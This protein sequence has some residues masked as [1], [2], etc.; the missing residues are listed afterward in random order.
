MG[1]RLELFDARRSHIEAFAKIFALLERTSFQSPLLRE[2]RARL[3]VQGRSPSR[4]LH[5][6]AVWAGWADLR[7]HALVHV[8]INTLV[9]W[10]W[11]IVWAVER[12]MRRVGA[13][14]SRWLSSVAEFTFAFS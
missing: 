13:S 14:V 6:L 5:A 10:D 3:D 9:L 11:H 7:F 12:W 2:L 8:V 4:H 1:T